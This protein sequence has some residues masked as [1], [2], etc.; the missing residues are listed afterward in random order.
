VRRVHHLRHPLLGRRQ[1]LLGEVRDAQPTAQVV[2]VEVADRG[3][4]GDGAAERL[5]RAELGADVHVQAGDVDPL[6]QRAGGGGG[7]AELRA[8]L[9]GE[10]GLVRVG[11]D[12]GRDAQQHLRAAAERQ[13]PLGVLLAVEHDGAHPGLE[14]HPQLRLRLGVAVQVQ[15]LGREAGAQGEVQLAAR[16][17]VAAQPLLGEDRQHGGAGEGL[18][19]ED[20]L[21]RAVVGLGERGEQRP[22]PVVQVRLGDDVDG[23]AELARELHGVAAADGQAALGHGGVLWVHGGAHARRKLPTRAV[24]WAR[25]RRGG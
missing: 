22:R 11:V 19:G 15:A 10:D 24:G 23:R 9:A 12:A 4:R 2:D 13:Q 14:R 3:E 8:G 20:D 17:D 5:H 18:G 6:R 16:G 21:A 7:H 25:G 1:L